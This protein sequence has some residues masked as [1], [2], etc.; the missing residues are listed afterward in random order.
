MMLVT[1]ALSRRRMADAGTH[2]HR[3]AAGGA[4][5]RGWARGL[6]LCWA[7]AMMGLVT[8]LPRGLTA[9]DGGPLNHGVLTLVMAG[10]SAGFVHGVGFIPHQPLLRVLLGPA[11]A[12]ACMGLG[13]FFYIEYFLR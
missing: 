6:S 4:L 13:L 3:P 11:V 2:P 5:D 9:A 12:W 1:S 10:M 7:V 8:L